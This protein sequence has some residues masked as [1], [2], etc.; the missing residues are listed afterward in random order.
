MYQGFAG[1]KVSTKTT[2]NS[3]NKKSLKK[4]LEKRKYK[5][6][7]LIQEVQQNN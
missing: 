7:K 1:L 6:M 4:Y 3:T 2:K 5:L